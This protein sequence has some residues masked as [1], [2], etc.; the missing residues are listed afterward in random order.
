M[1]YIPVGHPYGADYANA[2][3]FKFVPDKFVGR[4][5]PSMASAT[6]KH[7]VSDAAAGFD[8]PG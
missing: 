4:S 7:P 8:S 2:S 6:Q 1:T 3:S 5:R